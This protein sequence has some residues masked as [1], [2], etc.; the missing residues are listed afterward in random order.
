MQILSAQGG[1]NGRCGGEKT[2]SLG[3]APLGI[4][5]LFFKGG[6]KEGGGGVRH[7]ASWWGGPFEP[8]RAQ[9]IPPCVSLPHPRSLAPYQLLTAWVDRGGM[10]GGRGR[11]GWAVAVAEKEGWGRWCGG[12]GAFGRAS[13]GMTHATTQATLSVV[14]ALCAQPLIGLVVGVQN[15]P[16]VRGVPERGFEHGEQILQLGV[17]RIVKP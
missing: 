9:A 8:P 7:G 5:F 6:R 3:F 13:R 2:A 11:C 16:H 12:K 14:F 10:V 4:V 17:M 1:A 15:L